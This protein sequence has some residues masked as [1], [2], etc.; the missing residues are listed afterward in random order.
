MRS[1]VHH[2]DGVDAILCGAHAEQ[3]GP[4]LAFLDEQVDSL[5]TRDATMIVAT[6][7][8]EDS[9]WIQKRIH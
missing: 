3:E 8:G 4:I 5:L 6:G 7:S 9:Q 2:G 1:V